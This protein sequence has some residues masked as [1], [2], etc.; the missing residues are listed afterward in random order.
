MMV[1]ILNHSI[2]MFQ[3]H[4]RDP[5]L[6]GLLGSDIISDGYKIFYGIISDGIH[7]HPAALRIAHRTHPD[8]QW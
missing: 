7:T 6:V 8:G 3:F 4:H 1:F 2:F 5:G